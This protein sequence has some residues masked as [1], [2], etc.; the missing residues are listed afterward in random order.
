MAFKKLLFN[1]VES[2]AGFQVKIRTFQGFVEYREGSRIA[3]VPVE[4][5]MGQPLVNVYKDTEIIWNPPH[6]T[7]LI[8]EHERIEILENIVAALKFAKCSVAFVED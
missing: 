8:S 6:S 1:R 3:R 7:E 4:P 2:D 5:V